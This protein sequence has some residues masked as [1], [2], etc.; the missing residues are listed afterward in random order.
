MLAL[1]LASALAADDLRLVT[2]E[3]EAA[4]A[5]FIAE[6]Q[7]NEAPSAL[8]ERL[9]DSEGYRL[10]QRRE[11]SMQ[12]PFSNADFRKFLTA[13]ATVAE[14][15]ALQRTLEEW[16]GRGL[17]EP[18]RRA[19]AYLPPDTPIRARVFILIKPRHNSFVF[20]P[21]KAPA[22]VLYLDPARTAEQFENTAAHELHHIG[23]SAACPESKGLPP[24]LALARDFAKAF[25]E[26]LAMLAAAGGP[27]VHPHAASPASDRARWD[28]DLANFDSDLGAVER[29]L[30]DILD[31]RIADEQQAMKAAGPFWGETQGAWYTVG[32]KMA[33]MVEQKFGRARLIEAECDPAALL[34]DY[35]RA[36]E[37]RA[38]ARWSPSLLDRL[39]GR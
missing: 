14:Q 16:R 3:A 8:W 32:W 7:G 18:S 39:S 1:V 17:R 6:N 19:H 12:R 36:A 20:E 31:G 15:P 29:F 23:Y 37:G 26:G 30:L 5:I 27:D 33:A 10:L 22:I 2:D 4:I 24:K 34:R 21:K 9:F 25:G 28:R 11:E 35:N 13:P 38:L